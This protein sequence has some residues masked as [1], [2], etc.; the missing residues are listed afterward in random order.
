MTLLK[1][2]A[3]KVF[4]TYSVLQRTLGNSVASLSQQVLALVIAASALV[5]YPPVA[6]AGLIG[7]FA[8]KVV[9]HVAQ[10]QIEDRAK[11]SLPVPGR[12]APLAQ[13]SN[14]GFAACPQLFPNN[15]PL[16]VSAVDAHWRA[17]GLC[18]NHFAVLSSALSKTPLVVVEKLNRAMLS[19]AK[20]QERTN[21]FY[22]DPRLARGA[23]GELI[24]YKSSGF[25]RGHLASAA[26]QPDQQSVLVKLFR[27]HR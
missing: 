12:E 2:K 11:S 18:S 3:N 27:T 20:D 4:V 6:Q 5:S 25:D 16:D 13:S 26:N 17:V 23:R 19:D 1:L 7:M 15:A 10:S 21:E 8:S 9:E 24:D 22:A 14:Q